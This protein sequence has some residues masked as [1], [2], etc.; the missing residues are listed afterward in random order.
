MKTEP[1]TFLYYLPGVAKGDVTL[2]EI[3]RRGLAGRVGECFHVDPLRNSVQVSDVRGGPDGLH[4][5]LVVAMPADGSVP[6]R[7]EYVADQQ[8]WHE[9]QQHQVEGKPAYWVGYNRDT[10]PNPD[11]LVRLQT[12]SGYEHELPDGH[13]WSCPIIRRALYHANVPCTLSRMNGV[14]TREPLQQY[15]DAWNRSLEWANYE[16]SGGMTL[17]MQFTACIDALSLNYRVD[18]EEVSLL[19]LLTDGPVGSL[20]NIIEAALDIPW[21]REATSGDDPQKKRLWEA[22]VAELG[23]S[24]PGPEES[25]QITNRVT[26]T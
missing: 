15:R 11:G 18:A 17:E 12:V 16:F 5:V 22:I 6:H 1:S 4:G 7:S 26:Q 10:R 23:I 9:T 13:V 21:I 25:S 20:T 19:E 8:E 14:V 2:T 24:S 3:E